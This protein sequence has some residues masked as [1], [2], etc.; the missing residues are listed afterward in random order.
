MKLSINS[1]CQ[2]DGFVVLAQALTQYLRGR[3]SFSRRLAHEPFSGGT[4]MCEKVVQFDLGPKYSLHPTVGEGVEM[5]DEFQH[6]EFT[7]FPPPQSRTQLWT[8]RIIQ[9]N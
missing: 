2:F 5:P 7:S 6:A 4:G 3:S 9:Q 1:R 8:K